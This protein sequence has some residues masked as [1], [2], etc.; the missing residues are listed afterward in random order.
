M[1]QS[2]Q[3]EPDNGGFVVTILIG[4][5]K[6]YD[7]IPHELLIAK[8]TCYGIENESLRLLLDYLTTG[9]QRIKISS[10]FS[11]WCDIDTGVPQGSILSF[12]LFNIFIYDLFFS[13]T[14]PEVNNFADADTL[15]S[16]N[17]NL[18]HAFSNLK[19]DLRNVLD[20]FKIYS[21]KTNPGKF[22]FMLLGVKSRTLFRL[23][24][25]GKIIPCSNKVKFLG[26][27][28]DN[29]L[30]FKKHSEHDDYLS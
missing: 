28:I 26:I 30:K 13:I 12:L 10:A 4:L 6:A 15:C 21:M 1:L 19:Y 5:S 9:K 27:T 17:K 16:C 3:K 24:V 2:W 20:W 7:C 11:W 29:D 8:L 25:I 23:N 14:K 22:Q 18:E